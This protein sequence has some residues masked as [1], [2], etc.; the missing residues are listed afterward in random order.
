[1]EMLL[2]FSKAVGKHLLQV[3][4][5]SVKLTSRGDS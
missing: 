2:E 5:G 3:R 4:T 1:M